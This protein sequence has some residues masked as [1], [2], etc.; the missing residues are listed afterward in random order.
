MARSGLITVFSSQ[1]VDD[2]SDVYRVGERAG[3]YDPSL[4]SISVEESIDVQV[5]STGGAFILKLQTNLNYGT[6]SPDTSSFS[7]DQALKDDGTM[8]DRVVT[9]AGSS[10]IKLTSGTH[11]RYALTGTGSPEANVTVFIRGDVA[12][13]L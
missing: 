2:E 5:I 12:T 3:N 9:A 8:T 10:K 13:V 7:N 6:S 1:A 11:F 4:E